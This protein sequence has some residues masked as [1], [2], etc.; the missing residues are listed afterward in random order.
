MRR[1]GLDR[2]IKSCEFNTPAACL[3][4]LLLCL[5]LLISN[6]LTA[7]AH[8]QQCSCSLLRGQ[9]QVRSQNQLS[10]HYYYSARDEY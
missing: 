9:R 4:L 7:V 1:S 8:A 5:Y 10:L 6:G 3:L 2:C